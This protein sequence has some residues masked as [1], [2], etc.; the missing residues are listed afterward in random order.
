MI[1]KIKER[2]TQYGSFSFFEG[3]SITQSLSKDI[4]LAELQKICNNDTLFLVLVKDC[5]EKQEFLGIH[6]YK[7][8]KP[9]QWIMTNNPC[10]LMNN[11]GRTIEKLY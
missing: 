1:V 6:V 7:N 11:E 5:D 10:Y 2:G 9:V 3:D 4:S 8:H